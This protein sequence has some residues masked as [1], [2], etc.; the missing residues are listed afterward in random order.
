MHIFNPKGNTEKI[1]YLDRTTQMDHCRQCLHMKINPE[2][3]NYINKP[4]EFSSFNPIAQYCQ[5]TETNS[6]KLGLVDL[7]A[8]NLLREVLNLV[9]HEDFIPIFF[10]RNMY[11]YNFC[12]AIRKSLP[13]RNFYSL[14]SCIAC[15]FIFCPKKAEKSSQLVLTEC[16]VLDA[17]LV[18]CILS[19]IIL[20]STSQDCKFGISIF[21]LEIVTNQ[22]TTA[23][24][25]LRKIGNRQVYVFSEL[26]LQ[27]VCARARVS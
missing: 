17:N 21:H 9:K 6:T 24:E 26:V 15:I 12:L 10:P 5:P 2:K 19:L 20:E 11:L 27:T 7:F 14:I 23:M 13:A 1:N 18:I 8:C 22:H 16:Y 3:I 25:N 4:E